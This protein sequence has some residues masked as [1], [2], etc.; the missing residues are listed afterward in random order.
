MADQ[1]IRPN[2]SDSSAQTKPDQLE[3]QESQEQERQPDA[4]ARPASPVGPG[5]RPLFRA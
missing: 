4:A 2:I 5:R 1:E 3:R